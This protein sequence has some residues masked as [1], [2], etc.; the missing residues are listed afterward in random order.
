MVLFFTVLFFPIFM[1]QSLFYLYSDNFSTVFC[2]YLL[3]PYSFSCHFILQFYLSASFCV[4]F[5]WSTWSAFFLFFQSLLCGPL[6]PVFF[7][8]YMLYKSFFRRRYG[9]LFLV[10][11]FDPHGESFPAF[12]S[13]SVHRSI[14]FIKDGIQLVHFDFISKVFQSAYTLMILLVSFG[15]GPLSFSGY[16]FSFSTLEYPF[17]SQVNSYAYTEHNQKSY[18]KI[19]CILWK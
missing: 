4:F 16:D 18:T 1:I 13:T 8:F 11:W 9:F 2:L 17:L 6:Y 3:Q 7:S 12:K 10:H 14:P 19:F 5:Y 15:S